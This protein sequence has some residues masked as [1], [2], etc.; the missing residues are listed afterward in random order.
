MSEDSNQDSTLAPE[1]ERPKIEFPCADYMIKVV[2]DADSTVLDFVVG[3]MRR[4]APDLDEQ[5]IR[6]KASRNG[7]FS[8]V[9]FYIVATGEA[10]LQALFDELKA[11]S[12]V[13][14]VI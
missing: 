7:K 6:H 5:R 3:V 14:M 2:R 10:Q 11:H 8:S 13:Y 9:T 1:Q 4:H 12:G